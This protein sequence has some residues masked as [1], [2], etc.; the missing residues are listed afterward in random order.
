MKNFCL[1]GLGYIAP[2]HIKA[3]YET[4]NNLSAV[5]DIHN[6]SGILDKYFPDCKF[7]NKEKDFKKYILNNDIDY[8]VICSPNYLHYKHC[9]LGLELGLDVIC[10][11]PIILN[12]KYINKL[13]KI[14]KKTGHKIYPILQLRYHPKLKKLKEYINEVINKYHEINIETVTHRGDWY[15][16]S[17]KGQ[18]KKSGGMT[19]NI[20]VHIFD[21]ICWLFNIYNINEIDYIEIKNYNK[22]DMI[23]G[24]FGIK[25]TIVNFYLSNNKK[26]L[27]YETKDNKP[28]RKLSLDSYKYK[29]EENSNIRFDDI[30]EDLHLITYKEILK[31]NGYNIQDCK[32]SIDLVN[33]IYKGINKNEKRNDLLVYR[34]IRGRENDICNKI[35]RLFIRKK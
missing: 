1:I 32:V 8:L 34:F 24:V 17:W 10:E 4:N 22:D 7:F 15:N 3:I 9:K 21:L 12:T 14:E 16:K 30:F 20:G 27:L 6:S 18:Y 33:K 11:K 5:Y 25:N 19:L 28:Y 2:R 26:Y 23:D 31:G 13:T 35:K 29:H